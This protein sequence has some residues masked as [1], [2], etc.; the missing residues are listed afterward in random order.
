MR[1]DAHQH[2]WHY[3]ETDYDWIDDNQSYL[4]QDFLPAH[5]QPFLHENGLAGTIAV[6]A[7]QSLPETDYLIQLASANFFIKGVVG[8]VDLRAANLLA[9]LSKYKG[10]LVG[11]RHII[12]DEPE[13]DFM[14]Q[15]DFCR[16]IGMLQDF[17]YTYDLLIRPEHI[18]NCLKLIDR[19]PDQQFVID[20]IAKPGIASGELEPWKSGI[21]KLAERRNVYCKLSGMVTEAAYL[22]W[23]EEEVP[24]NDFLPYLDVLLDSFGAGR[25]MYGSDWPVCT[26]AAT[27][28]EVYDIVNEYIFKLS[29]GEQADIMGETATRFYRLQDVVS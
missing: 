28:G 16:G 5:L 15:D 24:L 11:V 2:F 10:E 25:L 3:N 17:D 13:T 9:T 6:Q 26:L 29:P 4:K 14:L 21:V 12:H 19:F 23:N 22:S 18:D 8:W 1:I 27:Y 20:H 7:R